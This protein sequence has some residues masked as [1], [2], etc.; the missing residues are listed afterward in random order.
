M[1][2][3]CHEARRRVFPLPTALRRAISRLFAAADPRADEDRGEHTER[4]EPVSRSPSQDRQPGQQS[5]PASI[6]ASLELREAS[7]PDQGRAAG[8]TR[9]M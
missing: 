4:D 6:E 1:G 5:K 9:V 3:R 7:L 8:A 2:K